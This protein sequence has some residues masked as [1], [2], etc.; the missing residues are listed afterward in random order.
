[1][2]PAGNW[3]FKKKKCFSKVFCLFSQEEKKLYKM[4]IKNVKKKH[5][6]YFDR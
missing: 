5:G 2:V 6:I 4:S 1:L 3:R